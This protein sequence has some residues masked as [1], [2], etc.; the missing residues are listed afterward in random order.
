M[1]RLVLPE[2]GP[3]NL[4]KRSGSYASGRVPCGATATGEALGT[5]KIAWSISQMAVLYT[6]GAGTWPTV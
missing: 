2:I 5:N 3:R 1:R 4:P 6:K